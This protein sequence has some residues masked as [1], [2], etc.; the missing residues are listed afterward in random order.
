MYGYGQS[1]EKARAEGRTERRFWSWSE[2]NYRIVEVSA[3]AGPNSESDGYWWVPE[4]GFSGSVKH[5]L[6]TSRQDAARAALEQINKKAA[7]IDRLKQNI[8]A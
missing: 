7:E 6:F 5:H 1:V 3:F 4:L 2:D 8:D